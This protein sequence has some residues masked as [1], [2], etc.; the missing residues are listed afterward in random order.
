MMP[1]DTAN[2]FEIKMGS[3]VVSHT[4]AEMG[5]ECQQLLMNKI[6]ANSAIS[7]HFT[8]APLAVLDARWYGRQGK[9]KRE[10]RSFDI[11]QCSPPHMVSMQQMVAEL[12]GGGVGV[13]GG[14]RNPMIFG[15]G[16]K[17]DVEAN[18]DVAAIV[19]VESSTSDVSGDEQSRTA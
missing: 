17:S 14:T 10:A 7:E 2:L 6:R 15:G 5:N 4:I 19:G 9:C 13:L 16:N 8:R 1:D 18:D 12:F 3:E 11:T